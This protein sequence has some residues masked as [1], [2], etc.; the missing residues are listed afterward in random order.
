M[1][2]LIYIALVL[3]V[4]AIAATLIAA[5]TAEEGYQDAEGFHRIRSEFP[6]ESQDSP[7]ESGAEDPGR[8]PF[9]TAN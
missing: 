3:G 5:L 6:P 7:G 1:H 9:L 8:P 2:P 4:G